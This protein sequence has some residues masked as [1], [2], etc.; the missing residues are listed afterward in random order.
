MTEETKQKLRAINTGKILSDETRKKMSLAQKG[1]KI[2][3]ANKISEA[4]IGKKRK[5][6]S[7]EH[8]RKI[9]EALKGEKSYRW[10]GGITSEHQKVRDSIEYKAWRLDVFERDGFTCKNCNEKGGYLEAHHI[11]NFHTNIEMRTTINNGITFC[12]KCHRKFHSI[13]GNKNNM[14]QIINY[15]KDSK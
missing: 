12:K 1:R 14:E 6:F 3:W 2:T 13:Y 15:L 9:G 8:K 10:K 4:K 5:P 11:E 7:E